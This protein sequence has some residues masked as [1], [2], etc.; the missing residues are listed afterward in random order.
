MTHEEEVSTVAR[1][2]EL[3]EFVESRQDEIG[4]LE[5]GTY[6]RSRDPMQKPVR[7]SEPT[8]RE[9]AEPRR[10]EVKREYPDAESRSKKLAGC[11][12]V[13]VTWFASCFG[14][15]LLRMALNREENLF[16]TLLPVVITLVVDIFLNDRRKRD[17]KRI[18]GSREFQAEIAE[19]DRQYDAQQAEYD[20]QYDEAVKRYEQAKQDARAQ[21][22]ADRKAFSKDLANYELMLAQYDEAKRKWEEVRDLAVVALKKTIGDAQDELDALYDSS[23]LIPRQFRNLDA[24]HA[25]YE[26]ISTSGFDVKVAINLYQQDRQRELDERAQANRAAAPAGDAGRERGG[27]LA[28]R[29]AER[30]FGGAERHR[31]PHAPRH[32]CRQRRGDGPEAGAAKAGR[33]HRAGGAGA[34][35]EAGDGPGSQG[36]P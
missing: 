13:I 5:R 29:E 25:I 35:E 8:L 33:A 19:L 27:R 2:I 17:G 4:R 36:V 30:P 26:T 24:L 34:R 16:F 10:Q 12:P 22:E 21:F 3:E 20:V 23:R 31:P 6:E 1:L 7:P 15:W 14:V 9:P 28:G 18:E 32:G 11:L